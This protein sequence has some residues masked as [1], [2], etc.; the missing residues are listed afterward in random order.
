MMSWIEGLV[1][2]RALKLFDPNE[3]SFKKWN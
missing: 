1:F 3:S 2:R